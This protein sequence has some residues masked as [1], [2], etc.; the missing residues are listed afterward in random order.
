MK[1]PVRDGKKIVWE[2][3][4]LSDYKRLPLA[5]RVLG[6]GR[7][8]PGGGRLFSSF[9]TRMLMPQLARHGGLLF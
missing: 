1:S 6:S 3:L 2:R 9:F 7:G 5:R 8:S 4:F